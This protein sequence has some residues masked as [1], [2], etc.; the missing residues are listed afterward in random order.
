MTEL[1]KF[2]YEV[3]VW[4][5][6]AV[7]AI[8]LHEAAHGYAAKRYGDA[9]AYVM[10]RLSLNPLVHVDLLGTVIVPLVLVFAYCLTGFSFIVGWAKPVPINPRNFRPFKQGFLVVSAAGCLCNFIQAVLWALLLKFLVMMGFAGQFLFSVCAAGVIVNMCLMGFNLFPVPPL[11]GGRILTVI[12]P[13]Q[14][15]QWLA[16]A[17]HY[18]LVILA[19]LIV[20]GVLNFWLSPFMRIAQILLSF[21]VM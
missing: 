10:G 16:Q 9:T 21:A 12:L 17:E 14:W 1:A 7:L 4:A 18:G 11:D 2:V 6:P 8:T 5:V 13:W 3:L 15:S 20:S 19:L